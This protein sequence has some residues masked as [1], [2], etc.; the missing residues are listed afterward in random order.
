M[1]LMRKGGSA[2]DIALYETL[3]HTANGYLGVRASPE[4]GAPNNA[5][6]IRGAYISGFFD[7][8]SIV[9]GEKL[10]GFAEQR[11]TIVNLPDV[12]TI[13]LSLCGEPFTQLS[14][15]SE[16]CVRELD[17]ERGIY[18]RSLTWCSPGGKHTKLVFERMASFAVREL[19]VLRVTVEPLD[20]SGELKIISTQNGNVRNDF[21]PHDPRKLAEGEKMLICD[22]AAVTD[23]MMILSCRTAHSGMSAA[24]A[25]CHSISAGFTAEYESFPEENLAV[26]CGAASRNKRIQITKYCIY[27]DSRRVDS[28]L[29]TAVSL[30]RECAR[31]AFCSW[32]NEQRQYLSQFWQRVIIEVKGDETLNQSLHY[33]AYSLL[34]ACGRDKASG[35]ASKGL[36]GEGYEGHNFWDTEIY[37]FPFFL[38]TDP[39]AARSLLDYRYSLL[40]KSREHARMLGHKSG[41]LYAWRTIDGAE[42]SGYF[43]SG[44]AQYH[45]NADI[46]HA[47]LDYYYA[48]SNLEYMRDKG[49]EVLIETARLWLDAGHY[50]ADGSF[51][52]DCVTGP[53]E[54]SCIVNNNFYTN[55][56]AK[57][58]LLGTIH[59]C[60]ELNKAALLEAV[61]QKTGITDEELLEFSKAAESMLLPFDEELGIRA[62]DDTFLRRK[63]LE[64][65]SLPHSDFPL[66]THYHPLW[67]YRHQ[68]CKQADAVLAHFLY[69]QGEN[70]QVIRRTYNYY[71]RITTHDSSLSECIF[72]MMAARIGDAQKA[73][74]YYIRSACL[75][76]LDTHGNT[77]DGIHAANMGGAW[78]GIVFGFGGLRIAE[79]G[80]SLKPCL[81]DKWD[82]YSF[83]VRF[84]GSVLLAEICRGQAVF[85][86]TQGKP[87][88][89]K[90]YGKETLIDSDKHTFSLQYH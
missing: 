42:C 54:Y 58:H 17:M 60:E 87:L 86:I 29:D 25:V 22:K 2:S 18:T 36:S 33:C 16:D 40:N 78:M 67:L 7:T 43:P 11:Q 75:D 77:R 21:D 83:C 72:S 41:A 69:E 73:Y 6:S 4:E 46:A 14:G 1:K 13:K 15:Q 5:R 89:I 88:L 35:I 3:F 62:Q 39:E 79:D 84:R 24:S 8:G 26:F 59:I 49:A 74:D 32:E 51:H 20:W 12:Q 50:A 71:E 44:S 48:T 47:F 90:V 64:L 56:A 37:M 19:F 66:L 76:L 9:Y 23:G 80:L 63:P 52:I 57:H 82:G 68:V 55:R 10:H 31:K 85:S 28:P 45:I 53:D 38:L 70:E 61:R 30:L 27:A 81:P 34:Q 65:A